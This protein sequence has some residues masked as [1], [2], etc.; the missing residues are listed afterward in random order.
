[1]KTAD[2]TRKLL[3]QNDNK[4]LLEHFFDRIERSAIFGLH[5]VQFRVKKDDIANLNLEQVFTDLGYRYIDTN[6]KTTN[7]QD[8]TISW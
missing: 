8:V 5:H 1:M 2:E 6:W 3:P 4:D 7:Y